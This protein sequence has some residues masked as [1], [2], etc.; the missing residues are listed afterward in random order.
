MM[1]MINEC[2]TMSGGAVEI[3]VNPSGNVSCPKIF[4]STIVDHMYSIKLTWKD[5]MNGNSMDIQQIIR[6]LLQSLTLVT[7]AHRDWIQFLSLWCLLRNNRDWWWHGWM[8]DGGDWAA[9]LLAV[10]EERNKRWWSTF[11]AILLYSY[12]N[13]FYKKIQ[14]GRK[15]VFAVSNNCFFLSFEALDIQLF[16]HKAGYVWILVRVADQP[17]SF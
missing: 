6:I 3:H 12:D 5:L 16:D 4:V 15:T 11:L 1:R 7:T 2:Y 9:E 14:T 8:F 10:L 17:E 13:F